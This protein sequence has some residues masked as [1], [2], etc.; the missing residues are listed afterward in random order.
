MR[1]RLFFLFIWIIIKIFRVEL[2][3]FLLFGEINDVGIFVNF[4]YL[5]KGW[6]IIRFVCKLWMNGIIRFD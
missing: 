2:I 6:L 5:V 1:I 4:K 3:Y